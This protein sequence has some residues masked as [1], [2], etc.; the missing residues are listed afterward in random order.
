MSIVGAEFSSPVIYLH[1]SEPKQFYSW[2]TAKSYN[3][4]KEHLVVFGG[5]PKY[6]IRIWN[7]RSGDW[8]TLGENFFSPK[9]I[10]LPP[11][12][13]CACSDRFI[14]ISSSRD[15][16]LILVDLQNSLRQIRLPSVHLSTITCISIF[17][18]LAAT[19]SYDR[20]VCL[21]MLSS[22]G[23]VLLHIF[24]DH[25]DEVW[26][27]ALTKKRL[28]SASSDR[29][30]RIYDLENDYEPISILTGHTQC[31]M[32]CKFDPENPDSRIFTASYDSTVKYW[33]ISH[34]QAICLMTFQGHSSVI[35]NI[36]ASAYILISV[37]RNG[38]IKIWDR[39][40]GE[41]I[42][43]LQHGTEDIKVVRLVPNQTAFF[44]AGY[45]SSVNLWKFK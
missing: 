25:T 2:E 8:K 39:H 17:G 35:F 18:D 29:T 32:S 27:V 37:G 34:T 22:S 41:C 1:H 20:R 5:A 43:S 42:R 10:D 26:S 45:G 24:Q 19:G 3:L 6:G 30:V 31:I 15:G 12:S 44:T 36:D 14:L 13:A 33:D 23:A 7:Y 40:T 28:A 4:D 9:G 11:W 16:S 21:W 38:E